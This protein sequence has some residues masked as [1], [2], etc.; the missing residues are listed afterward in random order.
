MQNTAYKYRAR[1]GVLKGATMQITV[2]FYL[3]EQE[4]EKLRK[5]AEDMRK[6]GIENTDSYSVEDEIRFIVSK[7]LEKPFYER[8]VK[9]K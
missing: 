5:T 8:E 1:G 4:L 2:E 9:E 3:D 7:E 6:S